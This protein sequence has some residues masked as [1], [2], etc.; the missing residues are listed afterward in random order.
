MFPLPPLSS[1]VTT[2]KSTKGHF[3][4]KKE[5]FNVYPTLSLSLRSCRTRGAT[6]QIR[7][8]FDLFDQTRMEGE[9]YCLAWCRT[10]EEKMALIFILLNL[11]AEHY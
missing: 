11:L 5:A 6:T 8:F 1:A 9:A 4:C 3:P 7:S 2:D 10:M